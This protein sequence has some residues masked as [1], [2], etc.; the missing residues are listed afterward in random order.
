MVDVAFFA[1]GWPGNVDELNLDAAGISVERHTIPVDAYLRTEVDHVFA[2]GDVN[3]HAMLVQVARLE[4]RIAAENAVMGP[5]RQVAYDVVPSASFTDP[6]YGRVGL[7]ETKATR[8]HDIVSSRSRIAERHRRKS[9]PWFSV[10]NPGSRR[11][12]PQRSRRN[13]MTS[14]IAHTGCSSLSG[15]SSASGQ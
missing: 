3:G 1:V 7:T 15:R 2:V 13:A 4:G 9:S 11:L 10:T 14:P 5:S 8:D 6:E 12:R